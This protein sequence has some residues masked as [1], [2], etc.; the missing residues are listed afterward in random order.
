MPNNS[1]NSSFKSG[2]RYQRDDE[3][4]DVGGTQGED[5]RYSR[6]LD[7]Q[8]RYATG[9]DED[10]HVQPHGHGYVNADKGGNQGDDEGRYGN[11]DDD[12]D[13]YKSQSGSGSGSNSR[14][15]SGAGSSYDT[16]SSGGY[17]NRNGAS[18]NDHGQN[19]NQPYEGQKYSGYGYQSQSSNDQGRFQQSGG[20]DYDRHSGDADHHSQSRYASYGDDAGYGGGGSHRDDS[21]DAPSPY[22]GHERDGHSARGG[23]LQA[24]P[25][26]GKEPTIGR[27]SRSGATA[28]GSSK[29]LS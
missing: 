9:E 17:G 21:R 19:R 18:G 28:G 3:G 10:R 12:G 2:S 8:S 14:Y 11:L 27:S 24:K 4:H 15:G 23:Y 1:Q 29:S 7:N 16:R 26:T 25:T 20:Q 6:G 22:A 13:D 5:G